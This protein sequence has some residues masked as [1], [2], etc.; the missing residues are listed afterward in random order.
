MSWSERSQGSFSIENLGGGGNPD[1]GVPAI[2]GSH[3]PVVIWA[4]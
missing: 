2:I 1:W 3:R 4:I